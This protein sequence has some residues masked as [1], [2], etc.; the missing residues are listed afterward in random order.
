MRGGPLG[1][2]EEKPPPGSAVTTAKSAPR[3]IRSLL[4]SCTSLM[5]SPGLPNGL[6]NLEDITPMRVA[7]VRHA[8]YNSWLLWW[9]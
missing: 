4:A 6:L 3:L 7:V 8:L 5:I 2:P 9:R 1:R